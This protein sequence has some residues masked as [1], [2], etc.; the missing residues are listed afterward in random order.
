MDRSVEINGIAKTLIMLGWNYHESL[1]HAENSSIIS[2][3]T[4]RKVSYYFDN[5]K[6]I[7]ASMDEEKKALV[8]D[9]I[10]SIGEKATAEIK[11]S[12][13]SNSETFRTM[14]GCNVVVSL[15]ALNSELSVVDHERRGKGFIDPMEDVLL[16]DMPKLKELN[17]FNALTDLETKGE[18]TGT[19]TTPAE[20]SQPKSQKDVNKRIEEY[21]SAKLYNRG[22]DA[23]MPIGGEASPETCPPSE[24]CESGCPSDDEVMG[25]DN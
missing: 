23:D 21:I 3:E 9:E 8:I 13:Q 18:G 12:E 24:G 4:M 5:I 19:P 17:V 10:K 20:G 16:D 22:A 7:F 1:Q 11:E 25:D 14:V 15:N 2:V 6:K